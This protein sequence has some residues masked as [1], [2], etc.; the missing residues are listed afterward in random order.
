MIRTNM[1]SIVLLGIPNMLQMADDNNGVAKE[2]VVAIPASMAIIA[3]I[4][5][6][7]PPMPSTFEPSRGL[8]ASEKL[9]LLLFLTW[10][11]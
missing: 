4:S 2:N 3:I 11:I 9:C 7:L 1:V 8:H 5:I 6:T 10:S